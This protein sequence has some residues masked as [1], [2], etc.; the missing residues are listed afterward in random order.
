MFPFS[1]VY[2]N[3]SAKYDG[4]E[5]AIIRTSK[6]EVMLTHDLVEEFLALFY[7]NRVSMSGWFSA[8]LSV[9][10]DAAEALVEWAGDFTC[11]PS[12][13]MRLYLFFSSILNLFLQR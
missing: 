9:F 2:C 5:D 7:K 8:K 10:K 3:D 13:G 6:P 11:G 4:C 12:C 1:Q